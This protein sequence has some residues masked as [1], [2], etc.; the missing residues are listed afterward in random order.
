MERS[1]RTS[2]A[3]RRLDARSRG[4]GPVSV[5]ITTF[6]RRTLLEECLQSVLRQEYQPL[7]IIVIDDHSSDDTVT[8]IT[9]RYPMVRLLANDIN[10]GVAHNR[11][12]GA[13]RA[14]G[15]FLL[16]LDDDA[17]LLETGHVANALKLLQSL[18][19][20]GQ[21]G[22]S[23]TNITRFNH[24][25]NGING[26]I[27]G[28]DGL[29]A[30]T[31]LS[32]TRRGQHHICH[33]VPG[34]N[35]FMRRDVFFSVGG[36]DPGIGYPYDDTDLGMRLRRRGYWAAIS[37]ETAAYHKK[38]VIARHESRISALNLRVRCIIKN[39]SVFAAGLFVLRPLRAKSA[40]GPLR[41]IVARL[42]GRARLDELNR[43]INATA[44]VPLR[45]E[46]S[47]AERVRAFTWNLARLPATLRA[48]DNNFLQ[49][50]Q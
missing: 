21:V 50:L 30:P 35:C 41:D 16:F 34:N 39:Q 42:G 44:L 46:P 24:N 43:A 47:F 48:R 22:G 36:L 38:S 3:D 33:Y 32:S 7:E 29:T 18:P 15:D 11:N 8:T 31:F 40:K 27:I 2:F 25:I 14:K 19:N 4:I 1:N 45:N 17:V 5:I 10:R 49:A 6:N 26:Y 12:V 28:V 20:I 9:S 37:W 23:L 13:L